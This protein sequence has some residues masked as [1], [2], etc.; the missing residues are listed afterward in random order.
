M[1]LIARVRERSGI[2]AKN[3]A[4]RAENWVS[5][6]GARSEVMEWVLSDERTTLATQISLTGDA[7]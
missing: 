1:T 6:G 3:G 7:T 5:G 2:G 4:E